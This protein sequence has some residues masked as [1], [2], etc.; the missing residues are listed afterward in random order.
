MSTFSDYNTQLEMK[1]ANT[2]ETFF[3]SGTKVQA[4]NDAIIEILDNY[5]I[6]E[7]IKRD[8]ITFV[9]GIKAKPDDYFRMVK[10]WDIDANG[11]ETSI[12]NYL[13]TDKFDKLAAN[14]AYWWT[15]DYVIADGARELK[16]LP[17][18]TTTI[19]IRYVK[20]PGTVDAAGL[21]DSNLSSKWDE[22]V[23]L[24]AAKRLFQIATRW[25][26]A[27]EFER[28]AREAMVR[29]YQAVKNP[30]GFKQ[31]VRLKSKWDRVSLLGGFKA[32][33]YDNYNN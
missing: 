29:V 24:V 16:V 8:E 25:D 32:G 13:E 23:A 11:V 2:S 30:G 26:E 12:F 17:T 20:T 33:S 9:S 4:V 18:D 3:D 31:G 6:P 28:L 5:D 15:E 22:V 1:I 21:T 27:R 14:S 19:Q 7:M 10:L